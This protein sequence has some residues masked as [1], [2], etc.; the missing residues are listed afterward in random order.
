M[1]LLFLLFRRAN[2][3]VSSDVGPSLRVVR[4]A[5]YPP[6]IELHRLGQLYLAG[7]PA[8]QQRILINKTNLIL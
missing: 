3:M 8:L 6:G 7:L 5:V 4:N 1:A 2:L